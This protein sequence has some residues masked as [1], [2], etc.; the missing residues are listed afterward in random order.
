MRRVI[1]ESTHWAAVSRRAVMSFEFRYIGPDWRGGASEAALEPRGQRRLL[2][3]GHS[4]LA[5]SQSPPFLHWLWR[6]QIGNINS[7][8]T[9]GRV[10]TWAGHIL[11]VCNHVSLTP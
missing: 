4:G 3:G 8:S 2:R 9:E 7:V 10:E 6:R 5:P 1:T 11:A